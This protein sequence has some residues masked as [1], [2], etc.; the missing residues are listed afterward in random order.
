MEKLDIKIWTRAAFV[1]LILSFLAGC[2][3]TQVM[4]GKDELVVNTKVSDSIF[5]REVSRAERTIYVKVRSLVADFP[6]RE[7]KRAVKDAII[8][9]DEGYKIIDDPDKATY[10][11]SI[12]VSNLEEATPTAAQAAVNTGYVPELAGGAVAGALL[13]RNGN[14]HGGAAAGGLL[15]GAGSFIANQMVKDVTF[16][17]VTDIRI[18]HKFR[19]GTYGRKD[20][21]VSLKA[22]STGS[23]SQRVSE[24]TNALEQTTRVV[25]TANQANLELIEAQPEMFRKHSYAIS[26]FF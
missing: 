15:V 8:D 22:G 16:M 11:L 25:T 1:A 4:L 23:S 12:I 18:T 9:A 7:F 17:L 14:R 5:V 21:K 19:K 13:S 24:V 3:A 10:Q 2:A 6:K 20:S 26:G